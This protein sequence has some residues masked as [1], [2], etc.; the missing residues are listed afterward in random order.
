MESREVVHQCQQNAGN[1]ER[2]AKLPPFLRVSLVILITNLTLVS[3]AISS[4]STCGTGLP[5]RL[6]LAHLYPS[7]SCFATILEQTATLSVGLLLYACSMS[8][9]NLHGS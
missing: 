5:G 8:G 3:M 9:H 7:P 4:S 1:F 6:S 2:I